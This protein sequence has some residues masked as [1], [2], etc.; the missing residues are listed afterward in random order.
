MNSLADEIK[1]TTTAVFGTLLSQIILPA[2]QQMN[3]YQNLVEVI[4]TISKKL[5]GDLDEGVPIIKELTDEITTRM[6]FL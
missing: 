6:F 2:I 3:E 1:P 4:D 5:S